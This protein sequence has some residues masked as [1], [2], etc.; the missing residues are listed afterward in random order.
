MAG[1]R[2]QAWRRRAVAGRQELMLVGPRR[3]GWDQP[4]RCA[5]E[6]GLGPR[7]HGEHQGREVRPGLPER[8]VQCGQLVRGAQYGRPRVG[9][10]R[11][12]LAGLRAQCTLVGPETRRVLL[13]LTAGLMAQTTR[14]RPC[15]PWEERAG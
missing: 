9:A 11:E 10:P 2:G 8:R 4:P 14:E 3:R 13:R 6:V 5:L 12:L 7:R 1:P 15:G